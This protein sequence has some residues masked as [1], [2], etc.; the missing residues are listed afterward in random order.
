[1]SKLKINAIDTPNLYHCGF[2][3]SKSNR[4]D[5]QFEWKDNRFFY[6]CIDYEVVPEKD[7]LYLPQEVSD[8]ILFYLGIL[9][10]IEIGYSK[11]TDLVYQMNKPCNSFTIF[12]PTTVCETTTI[13]I[14]FRRY[15]Q[16]L[17]SFGST[18]CDEFVGGRQRKLHI[19][20]EHGIDCCNSLFRFNVNLIYPILDAV[21][22]KMDY[23]CHDCIFLTNVVH[24]YWNI[25]RAILYLTVINKDDHP[26]SPPS[27]CLQLPIY[28]ISRFHAFIYE[29]R[30]P[31][32]YLCNQHGRVQY[33]RFTHD[34]PNINY[35]ESNYFEV[36]QNCI[37][38][39]KD[40]FSRH[41][42]KI[43]DFSNCSNLLEKEEML[44]DRFEYILHDSH[45]TTFTKNV[46][47]IY[48]LVKMISQKQYHR[49]E[50]M[51]LLPT[52]AGSKYD[53]LCQSQSAQSPYCV[54]SPVRHYYIFLYFCHDIS[55]YLHVDSVVGFGFLYKQRVP[56]GRILHKFFQTRQFRYLD[57]LQHHLV[58]VRGRMT[59]DH[60]LIDDNNNQFCSDFLANRILFS[61]ACVLEINARE[62][63]IRL[64]NLIIQP[65]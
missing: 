15:R 18:I 25:S 48:R 6:P 5:L 35:L 55:I 54:G 8:L 60:L 40:C 39:I 17:E 27:S 61:D 30:Y 2:K 52:S 19:R 51:I 65:Q 41:K 59:Y 10:Y 29:S 53:I 37:I 62:E 20:I 63:R 24:Q 34:V 31:T 57:G 33:G 22:I 45:V 32:D 14:S 3:R 64:V 7:I 26:P 47:R 13:P 44:M 4:D 9:Y 50:W 56:I 42:S 49:Y 11:R 43:L 21:T 16:F 46:T 1:M 58:F 28:F 12:G 23:N 36:G 38:P